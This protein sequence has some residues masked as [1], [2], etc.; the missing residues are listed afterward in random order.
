D[1]RI[2]Q[3]TLYLARSTDA[4]PADPL[5]I[6]LRL[7]P[8]GTGGQGGAGSVAS[9]VDGLYSTRSNATDWHAALTGRAPIGEWT[10]GLPDTPAVR[11]LFEAEAIDDILLVVSYS[12]SQPA[13]PA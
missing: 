12:A 6:E 2:E 4:P 1:L 7:A 9:A 3:L 5:P 8:S 10:L 13:W 11:A